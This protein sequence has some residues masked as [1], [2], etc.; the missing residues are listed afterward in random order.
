MSRADNLKQLE[1][2]KVAK[3]TTVT[4]TN[5]E[6]FLKALQSKID[7]LRKVLAV[8]VNV[9]IDDLVEQ[10][11]HIE[12]V[13]P[14]VEDLKNAVAGIEL[15]EQVKLTGFKELE[16]IVNEHVESIKSIPTL[17]LPEANIKVDVETIG[18][19]Q[20]EQITST[21]EK[22]ISAIK[23]NTVPEPSQKAADYLPVRRVRYIG[24]RLIFDDDVWT[25]SSG[26]GGGIP[27][28]L[29]RGTALAIVN[30]AGGGVDDSSSMYDGATQVT[31]KFKAISA[32]QNGDNDIVA[33]VVGKKIRVLSYAFVSSGTVN[34]KWQSNATDLSG[35]MYFIANTG[36]SSG[37]NPKGHFETVA[38]EALQLN[39][40]GAVPVGGHINYVE[41]G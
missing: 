17:E 8:D 37:Y 34:V 6:P 19:E 11:K 4:V 21:L 7:E 14:L 36:I 18:K 29:T 33:A 26:G 13:A 5:G 25:G 23:D 2:K 9:D 15:P 22:V 10:L 30:A 32:S 20:T 38:G 12:K 3:K 1:S 24:N 35:L 40:S 16:R 28:S 27:D 31:P 41:V 39:L